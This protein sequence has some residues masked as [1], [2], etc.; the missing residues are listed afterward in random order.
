MGKAQ[1]IKS[2]IWCARRA[3]GRHSRLTGQGNAS[4]RVQTVG[5][6]TNLLVML[7]DAGLE[8]HGVVQ[9]AERQ[10]QD[11]ASD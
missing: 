11:T 3:I 9:E 7:Q 6:V 2:R 10:F 4:L 8:P 5:L 1:T